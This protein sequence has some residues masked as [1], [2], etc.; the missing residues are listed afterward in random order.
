M[1]SQA[2]DA[3]GV[4]EAADVGAVVV[5]GHSYG[6]TIGLELA[7]LAPHAVRALVLV[8]PVF[9]DVPSAGAAGE[10]LARVGEQFREGRR[11]ASFEA[12]LDAFHGPGCADRF[13]AALP[14]TWREDSLRD[15]DT[16]WD[17]EL[18]A[19]AAWCPDE[20]AMRAL[21]TPVLLVAGERSHTVFHESRARLQGWW[22]HAASVTL[23]G[24]N[25]D[26]PS[27]HA[28]ALAAAICAFLGCGPRGAP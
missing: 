3:L 1:A 19:F 28:E 2:Q 26:A 13:Q 17:H 12:F 15:Y 9:F 14:A 27:S 18:P 5:V 6:A 4:I 7:R 11:A 16:Y 8:E 23:P 22:P 24:A 25:H 21:A 10:V 20:A